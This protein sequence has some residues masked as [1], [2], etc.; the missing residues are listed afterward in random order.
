MRTA[1]IGP[2]L[3]LFL[4]VLVTFGKYPLTIWKSGL[5]SVCQ[6]S[7]PALSPIPIFLSIFFTANSVRACKE[8][9]SAPLL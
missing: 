3:R 4:T 9:R 8:L 7:N 2:D 5:D 6:G 1:K